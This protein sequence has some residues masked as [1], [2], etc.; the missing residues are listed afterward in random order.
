MNSFLRLTDDAAPRRGGLDAAPRGAPEHDGARQWPRVT[1]APA[2]VA[3]RRGLAPR[4]VVLARQHGV[5]GGRAEPENEFL[6]EKVP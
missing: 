6:G 2:A 1:A 5:H 3:V 4:H